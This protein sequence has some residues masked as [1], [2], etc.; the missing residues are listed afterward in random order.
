[1]DMAKRNMKSHEKASAARWAKK[2]KPLP[3]PGE[4]WDPC[5]NGPA[6]MRRERVIEDAA[7]IDPETGEIRNPNGI[8]R[9]RFVDMLEVWHKRETIST[10][11]YNFAVK[12]RDA[13]ET[14]ERAPGW[15]DNDRV[16]S[17]P[18]P[19]HAVT[20]QIDRLCRFHAVARFVSREDR[21]VVDFFV[22]QRREGAE[23][24]PGPKWVEALARLGPALDRCA[25]AMEQPG[26]I[27]RLMR[28]IG[29]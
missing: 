27:G 25:A 9:A 19:D 3:M 13:F 18:K 29:E 20:I 8:R 14:T 1:M 11:G 4:L 28:R 17:S 22:L 23:I 5:A 6:N 21:A 26:R 10:A 7:E 16:Q 2:P 15:P 24:K 12:L